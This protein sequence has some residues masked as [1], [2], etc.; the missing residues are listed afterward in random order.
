MNTTGREYAAYEPSP[1]DIVEDIA[2]A[3]SW[4][5]DRL[6]DDQIAMAAEGAWRTY[7]LSLA[8]FDP[9]ETLRMVCTFEIAPPEDRLAELYKVIEAVNDRLWDGGFNLWRDQGLMAFRYGLPLHGGAGATPE[10]VDAMLKG[11]VENCEC[12][13]PAFYLV[14]YEGAT[15]EEAMAAA[16]L[17]AAGSA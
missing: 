4:D 5:V 8:W 1:I 17:E 9:S 14:A 7:S 15:A 13:F 16:L 3:R 12:Y 10:Q 11:A 2:E 6:G